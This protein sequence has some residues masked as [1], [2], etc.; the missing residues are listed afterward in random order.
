MA[1]IKLN[2]KKYFIK[3]HKLINIPRPKEK[4]SL[5]KCYIYATLIYNIKTILN[6]DNYRK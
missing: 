3:I 6:I 4:P 1:E 5:S 2:H